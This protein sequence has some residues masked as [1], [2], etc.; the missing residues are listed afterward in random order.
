[1]SFKNTLVRKVVGVSLCAVI[2]FTGIT[3]GHTKQA[4]AATSTS[5]AD[6]IISLG[7]KYIGVKY[8]FGAPSGSTSAFDCSSFTQYIFGKYGVKLPRVSSTQATKGTKVAKANLKKGDLVFFKVART[9]NKIGHVGVYVGDNKMLHTY[10]SPG[11]TYSSINTSYW[12]SNYVTAR[13]VL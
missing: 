6:N 5:K 10:G 2:G 8:R 11:V 7:K 9:G 3:M 4:S 12:K 1:M 13:R